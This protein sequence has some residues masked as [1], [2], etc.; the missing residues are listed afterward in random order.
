M[1]IEIKIQRQKLQNRQQKTKK[2]TWPAVKKT[3]QNRWSGKET[4]KKIIKSK[5]F[6]KQRKKN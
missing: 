1:Y 5:L 6:L 4:G 3:P 2:K